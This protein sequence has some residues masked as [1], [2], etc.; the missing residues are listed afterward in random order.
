MHKLSNTTS[1]LFQQIFHTGINDRMPIQSYAMKF[2]CWSELQLN[3]MKQNIARQELSYSKQIARKLRTQYADDIYDNSVT[4]K[5]RLTVT[6]GH[7]KRNDWVDHTR[8][9]IRRVIKRWILSW[10]WNVGQR[11][12]K[13][14]EN[15][16][17]R[18]II[19]DFLLVGDCKYS[20][21]LY[22]FRVFL[23]WII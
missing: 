20:S 18:W 21:I 22:H 14:I 4:L 16:A 23:R 5:S 2:V 1:T 13:V 15:G 6:Q 8:L 11:S 10:P 12:F 17:I 7:W 3:Q 19:C 9:T